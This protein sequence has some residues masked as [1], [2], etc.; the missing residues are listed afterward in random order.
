[1]TPSIMCY[2]HAP[3]SV[4][5]LG[6]TTTLDLKPGSTTTQDFKPGSTTTPDF[7]PD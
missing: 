1:M 2:V 3:L 7:E 6:P 4:E 5:L